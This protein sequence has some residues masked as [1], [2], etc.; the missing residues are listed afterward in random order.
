MHE[1]LNPGKEEAMKRNLR[2]FCLRRPLT[3]R[4]IRDEVGWTAPGTDPC[5]A[6]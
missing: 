3:E 2:G 1:D 6:S 5:L 4:C